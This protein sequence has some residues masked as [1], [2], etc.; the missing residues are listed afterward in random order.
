MPAQRYIPR[1]TYMVNGVE[2][3]TNSLLWKI[4]FYQDDAPIANGDLRADVQAAKAYG[5]AAQAYIEKRLALQDEILE[6]WMQDEPVSN[7]RRIEITQP[8]SPSSSVPQ[9]MPLFEADAW[10]RAGADQDAFVGEV[11]RVQ[12]TQ[13]TVRHHET[14]EERTFHTT[15]LAV[16]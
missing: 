2:T 15:E 16:L 12:G 3:P 10:V 7:R 5:D 9:E 8:L 13:V 6:R 11:T 1:K 4:G 14:N